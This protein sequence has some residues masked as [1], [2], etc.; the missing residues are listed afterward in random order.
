MPA[1]YIANC[2]KMEHLFCF[3]LKGAARPFALPIKAGGQIKLDYY[4][5]DLQQVIDQ[6]E[7]YGFRDVNQI[8]KGFGG[9][10]YRH[11]M[12]INVEA[13]EAG[14]T[15]TEQDQIDR[16]LEVRKLTAAATDHVMQEEAQKLGVTQT[17]TTEIE[18]IEETR[19]VGDSKTGKFNETIEVAKQGVKLRRNR[20]A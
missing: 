6:H 17:G 12:P 1:L 10:C 3:S 16:A 8:G 20:G 13:I 15:Q 19:G 14:I 4:D 9:L 2:S 11:V 18:V 5:S 7:Q